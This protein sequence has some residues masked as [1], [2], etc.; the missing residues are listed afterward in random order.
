MPR[1]AVFNAEVPLF[2][3]GKHL[4]IN[5]QPLLQR[6]PREYTS[7]VSVGY[8][9]SYIHIRYCQFFREIFLQIQWHHKRD[10]SCFC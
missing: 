3:E 7:T 1:R 9:Y 8:L 2:Y 10:E 4:F 6:F 5:I